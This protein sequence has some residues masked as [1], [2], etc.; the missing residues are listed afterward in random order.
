MGDNN[1]KEF[2]ELENFDQKLANL[3]KIEATRRI[4][5]S[6]CAS[7][8]KTPDEYD[9]QETINLITSFVNDKDT[10]LERLLYSEISNHMFDLRKEA[11]TSFLTNLD[12]LLEAI[13]NKKKKSENVEKIIVKIYDHIHLVE[14]QM[15]MVARSVEEE[16]KKSKEEN[17]KEIKAFQKEYIAILSIFSAVVLAFSGGLTFS[18]SVLENVSEVSMYRLVFIALLIGFVLLNLFFGLFHYIRDILGLQDRYKAMIILNTLFI[19]M[20]AITFVL[21][22]NGAIESRNERVQPQVAQESTENVELDFSYTK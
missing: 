6:I 2:F 11:Q 5:K 1:Y 22:H 21:W 3:H 20:M 17:Q 18:S 9:P 19:S 4:M 13:G 14:H 16:V 7:L 8:S 10:Y 12:A 15:G